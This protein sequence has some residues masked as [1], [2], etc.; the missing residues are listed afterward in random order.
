M[1]V[2]VHGLWVGCKVV[3]CSVV[4]GVGER[5]GVDVH[6]LC[7]GCKV[8][9]CKVVGGVGEKVGV[10]VHGLCVGCGTGLWVGCKVAGAGM[11]KLRSGPYPNNKKGSFEWACCIVATYIASPPAHTVRPSSSPGMKGGWFFKLNICGL[12]APTA[13][14]ANNG[15]KTIHNTAHMHT[16]CCQDHSAMRGWPS[17]TAHKNAQTATPNESFVAKSA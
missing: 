1:G 4:G 3:G 16:K 8:V 12:T 13:H 11:K 2:D 7:V 9:G 17:W 14:I 15:T 5:V 6:G 10:D